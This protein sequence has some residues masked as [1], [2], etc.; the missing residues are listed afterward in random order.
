[1]LPIPLTWHATPGG[2]T[3][4]HLLYSIYIAALHWIRPEAPTLA[5]TKMRVLKILGGV[6]LSPNAVK[7]CI[8]SWVARVSL[9]IPYDMNFV[10]RCLISAR[11]SCRNGPSTARVGRRR[12]EG[13][14]GLRVAR[15]RSTACLDLKVYRLTEYKVHEASLVPTLQRRRRLDLPQLADPRGELLDMRGVKLRPYGS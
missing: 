8:A 6:C 11:R 1:M 4:R 5:S 9:S 3:L 10:S 7:T 15:M 2:I 12:G 13:S 14:S